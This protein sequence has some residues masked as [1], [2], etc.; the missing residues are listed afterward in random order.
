MSK[1]PVKEKGKKARMGKQSLQTEIQVWY[2]GNGR[3]GIEE[4]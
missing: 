1:T 3:E 4:G 2:L